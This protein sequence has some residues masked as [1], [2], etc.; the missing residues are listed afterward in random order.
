M[1]E[2]IR[3]KTGRVYGSLIG[4]LTMVKGL[5]L[6]YNKD[7]QED[8][9]AVFDAA[10]TVKSCLSVFCGMLESMSFNTG[11]MYQS[12]QGG[13]TN[14]TDAADWLAKKGVP[15]REAHEITG[16]LVRY[17]LEK[18][19]PLDELTLEELK[20]ISDIFDQTIY[21]AISVEACVGARNVAGGPA[22]GALLKAIET[23]EVFLRKIYAAKRQNENG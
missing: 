18:K 2:L 3:G 6:A 8:K 16:K 12:A 11:N 5:P 17:A 20:K 13:Y 22:E 21:E 1:A 15:F 23:A 10:D 9:E 4:L 19:T 7:M 14:A